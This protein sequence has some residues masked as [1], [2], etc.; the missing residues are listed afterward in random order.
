MPRAPPV[1]VAAGLWAAGDGEMGTPESCSGTSNHLARDG[2]ARVLAAANSWVE[3]RGW[4]PLK[5]VI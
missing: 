1:P 2:V 3:V 5:H 4:F